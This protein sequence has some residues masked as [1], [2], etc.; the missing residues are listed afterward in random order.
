[1][2]SDGEKTI[3][4]SG[5]NNQILPNADT[6][7]QH[8]YVGDDAVAQAL[9]AQI[10]P[11]A[12]SSVDARLLTMNSFS[13]S[14]PENPMHEI[15]RKTEIAFAEKRLKE[16]NILCLTGEEGVGLTTLLAQ[17]ARTHSENC[18]S[19]S[20]MASREYVWSQKSWRRVS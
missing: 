7:I 11:V 5:G 4:V 15:I 19:I 8:I 1:M 2:M 13:F 18:V 9:N 16:H 17:F 10:T 14:L 3:G 20:M 12:N 6:A